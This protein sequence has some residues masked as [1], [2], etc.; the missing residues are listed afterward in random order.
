MRGRSHVT[1]YR[2]EMH[3]APWKGIGLGGSLGLGVERE[4]EEN[5]AQSFVTTIGVVVGCG[6][7]PSG[8]IEIAI[9][10]TPVCT[11]PDLM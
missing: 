8:S 6:E 7:P 5:A 4:S 3:Q 9:A 1:R 11:G 10:D 2:S